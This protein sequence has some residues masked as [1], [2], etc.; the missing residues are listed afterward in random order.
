MITLLIC[1][2]MYVPENGYVPEDSNTYYIMDW[3]L[4]DYF[5]SCEAQFD[6]ATNGI[7]TSQVCLDYGHWYMDVEGKYEAKILPAM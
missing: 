1:I 7:R 4:A 6:S 5:Q 3:Q 2:L